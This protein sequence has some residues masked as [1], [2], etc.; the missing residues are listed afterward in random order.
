MSQTETE[1]EFS[2]MDSLA[3]SSSTSVMSQITY[4]QKY[5]QQLSKAEH[6]DDH[7]TTRN[8]AL[9]LKLILAEVI[10]NSSKLIQTFQNTNKYVFQG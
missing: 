4:H 6:S 2:E 9:I 8:F 7:T 10:L 3:Y 5:Q 1:S